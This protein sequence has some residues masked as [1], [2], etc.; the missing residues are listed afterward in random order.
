MDS[1]KNPFVHLVTLIF[2]SFSKDRACAD[3][4]GKS[5]SLLVD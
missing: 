4:V 2:P 5:I 3:L 1:H